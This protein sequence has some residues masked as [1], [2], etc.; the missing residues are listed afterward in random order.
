MNQSQW[1]KYIKKVK[2][3]KQMVMNF[4]KSFSILFILNKVLL[5][6]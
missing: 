2:M 6:F 3:A 4:E 5:S 1:K